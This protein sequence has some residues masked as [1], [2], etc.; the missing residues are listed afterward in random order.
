M[1]VIVYK[2]KNYPMHKDFVE[3]K[4]ELYHTNELRCKKPFEIG[5]GLVKCS[6]ADFEFMS[7]NLEYVGE[8]MIDGEF[9]YY[10]KLHEILGE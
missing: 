6:K 7:S 8:G 5:K 3:I 2:V 4:G 1:K 9:S 10:Y